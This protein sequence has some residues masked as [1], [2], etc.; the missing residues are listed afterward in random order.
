MTIQ[1]KICGLSTAETVDAAIAAGAS[2]VGF[3]HFEKSPR[4]VALTDAASLRARLPDHVRAVLLLVN[5]DIETT[6]RAIDTV[7]PDVIQ[8][9]GTETPEWAGLVRTKL[10]VEVWK[11]L[12][13]RDAATLEKSRRYEG[14]VDRLLFDAPAPKKRGALPG[15][16]GEAFDWR[17]LADFD[18][19]IPWALAGGL[20]PDNVTEAIRRTGADLVDTSSGVE[21]APGVKDIGR[22]T[23]FCEAVRASDSA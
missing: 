20:S 6:A 10:N 14:R 15:G 18:H 11:A 12:G 21:S 17:L 19:T 3:V 8:F 9:H 16:N 1:I 7:K 5:A 13:V 2:Q 22:I 23:A 4:H